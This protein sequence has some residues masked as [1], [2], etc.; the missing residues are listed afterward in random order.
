[1]QDRYYG[2]NDPVAS[3]IMAAHAETQGLAP[4]SDLSIVSLY[5]TVCLTAA[6]DPDRLAV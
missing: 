3:K 4:P 2:R 1:M 6:I 5:G